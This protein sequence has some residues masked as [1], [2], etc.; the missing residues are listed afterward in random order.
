[1]GE[2]EMRQIAGLLLA[3]LRDRE[4]EAR[5]EAVRAE[6]EALCAGYPVPGI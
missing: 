2:E 5:L 6:V 1:M 4:D 3:A